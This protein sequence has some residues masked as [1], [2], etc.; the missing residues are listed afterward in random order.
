MAL[1]CPPAPAGTGVSH[2]PGQRPGHH[3]QAAGAAI[4]AMSTFTPGPMEELTA[5]FFT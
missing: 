5:T 2:A 1:P 4:E 3:D